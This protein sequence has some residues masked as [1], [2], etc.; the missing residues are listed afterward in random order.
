MDTDDSDDISFTYSDADFDSLEEIDDDEDILLPAP[1]NTAAATTAPT[2]I[3]T[4]QSS[5][6]RRARRQ[7]PQRVSNWRQRMRRGM[8]SRVALSLAV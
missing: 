8:D 7:D 2:N 5:V 1:L 6:P 4:N 3:P